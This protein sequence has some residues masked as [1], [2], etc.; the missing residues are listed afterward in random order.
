MA[1]DNLG[2]A[3]DNLRGSADSAP[4]N[5]LYKPDEGDHCAGVLVG[6]ST[7][8]APFGE[9]EVALLTAVRTNAGAADPQAIGRLSLDAAVLRRELSATTD[10]PPALGSLISVRYAGFRE[11][12]AGNRYRAFVVE[13][14]DPTPESRQVLARAQADLLGDDDELIPRPAPRREQDAPAF[15]NEPPF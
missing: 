1:H 6:Y 10:D 2:G 5:L 7:R 9:V 14:G 13:K 8:T 3:L 12:R 4:I 11:S 15:G